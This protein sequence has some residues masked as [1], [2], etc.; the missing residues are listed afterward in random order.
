MNMGTTWVF[1]LLIAMLTAAQAQA[2]DFSGVEIQA[3]S[4][5][6]NVYALQGAGGNLGLVVSDDGAFLIDDQY[7]PLTD[8]ILTAIAEI[9]DQ[10]VKFVLN[11]HWHNDHTGGNEN[12]SE[13]GALIVAHDN[14]RKRLKAGQLIEFFNSEVPP[15][16]D[17]ALPVVTFSETITFHLG[18]HT[19]YAE[20]VANAHTDGDSIV[21]LK[22]ADVIHSGDLVF[23]GMYPFIDYS[24]GGNLG[25]MIKAADRMLEMAGVDTKIIAGHGGP[26][27]NREQLAEY[28]NLLAVVNERMQ[29]MLAEGKTLEQVIE[30][31]PLAEF[32]A[33]WGGGFINGERWIE[34]IYHGMRR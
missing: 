12:M 4:V 29:T 25:G 11:T 16:P 34:M 21:Q 10:P 23:H 27:I 18:G 6:E 24:S 15:A 30:S 14:V 31:D 5:T 28:R 9:T 32:D 8:K 2:Q 20:H 19:V 3:T 1:L 17:A 7:A 22:E 33:D 13:T 26:V